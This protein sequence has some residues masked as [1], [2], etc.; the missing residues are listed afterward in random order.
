[1]I[2]HVQFPN[3][4]IEVT[5][6]RVAFS[7]FGF[8]IYWYGVIF[9]FTIIRGA[10]VALYLGKKLG[11]ND[12]DF[13]DIIMLGT[14]FGIIGARAYYVAFA[15]F[16]YET[17]WDMI[18]LRDG[19]IGIYGGLI[20]GLVS[21]WFLCKWK[22]I[23]FFDAADC[24]FTGFL[25][26]QTFG[27]WANFMNQEAF[28][29]NTD[30]L[31]G[32]ISESTTRYLARVAPSLAQQG[33][34]VDPNM[35]V[36]PTFLYESVWCAIGFIIL[37]RHFKNRKFRGEMLCMSGAWYGFGR[38]FIEG[39][40]TDSLATNGGLRTSQIIAVVTVAAAVIFIVLNYMK[41]NKKQEAGENG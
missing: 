6:N 13:I 40:R 24:I 34:T 11:I 23:N 17:L 3:L 10:S 15:P 33:I 30:G 32:M 26:G 29:T 14:V 41:I 19:G 5:I 8:D 25:F 7:V 12:D 2:N 9:A 31:F 35:P 4:G 21:G 1:M 20:A 28:G 36:H 27:R 38:F 16:E 22:K 37:Y 39:Q 18:N